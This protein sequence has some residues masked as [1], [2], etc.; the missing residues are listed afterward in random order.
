MQFPTFNADIAKVLPEYTKSSPY[1]NLLGIE[2][3]EAR[4]GVLIC[5]VPVAPKHGSGV[6]A[7]HGG[8][9]VSLVDHALSLAVY[10]LVEIGK[11]VATLELKMN[12]LAPVP[13]DASGFIVCEAQVLSLKKIVGVVRAD[14]KWQDQLVATATGT[15]YVKDPM[16]K[17]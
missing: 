8:V 10:P 11:W 15:V 17:S 12:Y 3:V 13:A 1:A 16:K 9:L 2:I 14:V 6:G 5:R 7:V 4:A